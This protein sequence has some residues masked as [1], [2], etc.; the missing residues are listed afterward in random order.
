MVPNAYVP[1]VSLLDWEQ[2][3]PRKWRFAVRL[4]I[5]DDAV[6]V[7]KCVGWIGADGAVHVAAPSLSPNEQ[8]P[9]RRSLVRFPDAWW[10]AIDKAV[11]QRVEAELHDEPVAE[12]AS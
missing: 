4:W 5:K 11:H 3:N 1:D 12:A 6:V 7:R 10:P 8:Y 2:I 9:L